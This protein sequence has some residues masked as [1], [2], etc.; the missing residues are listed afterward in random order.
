MINALFAMVPKVLFSIG[1][2]V[3]SEKLLEEL[4]LWSLQKL[5][6]SS[7]TTVDDELFAMVKKALED[8]KA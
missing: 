8:K 2:K 4:L 7:K 1:M 3:L 5:A 6:E